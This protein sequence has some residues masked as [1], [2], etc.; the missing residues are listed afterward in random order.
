MVTLPTYYGTMR[1]YQ[2]I[3]GS[4]GKAYAGSSTG[5]TPA[6]GSYGLFYQIFQL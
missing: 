2:M 4:D 1:A 5:Y 6:S 3:S